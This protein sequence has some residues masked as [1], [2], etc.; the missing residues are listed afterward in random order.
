MKRESL[1]LFLCGFLSLFVS[2]SIRTESNRWDYSFHN[3]NEMEHRKKS[4]KKANTR[5]LVHQKRPTDKIA[6][7]PKRDESFIW[8]SFTLKETNTNSLSFNV[9]SF[10]P[11]SLKSLILKQ[12]HWCYRMNRQA[13]RQTDKHTYC[14]YNRIK[15]PTHIALMP[16]GCFNY[17]LTAQCS[18]LMEMTRE[19]AWHQKSKMIGK[20]D[21]NPFR[22]L[23]GPLFFHS[24]SLPLAANETMI[25]HVP[26]TSFVC[27]TPC[28]EY[29]LLYYIRYVDFL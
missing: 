5:W 6:G 27:Y 13:G 26:C 16:A 9:D 14:T 3:S 25:F 8:P 28:M 7:G 2:E 29:I 18:I 11:L 23:S 24:F 15:N 4:E 10:F 12:H 22:M 20:Y 17:V 21:K 1:F 19:W